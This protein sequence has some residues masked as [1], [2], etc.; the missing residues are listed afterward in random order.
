M[1][2]ERQYGYVCIV[3]KSQSKK[4]KIIWAGSGPRQIQDM[5]HHT[6]RDRHSKVPCT[7]NKM[8]SMDEVPIWIVHFTRT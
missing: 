7:Q 1:I 4:E 8:T 5:V 2:N 3:L 6:L